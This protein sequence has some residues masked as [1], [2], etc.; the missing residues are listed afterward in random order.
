M[1]TLTAT[2]PGA[3]DYEEVREVVVYD[4]EAAAYY[5]NVAVAY[6]EFSEVAALEGEVHSA[7]AKKPER[8][9]AKHKSDRAYYDGTSIALD[10][11]YESLTLPL[12]SAYPATYRTR[13]LRRVRESVFIPAISFLYPEGVAVTHAELRVGGARDEVLSKVIDPNGVIE[14]EEAGG[15]LRFSVSDLPA[16]WDEDGAPDALSSGPAVLLA[17]R[18]GRLEGTKG[19]FT[20]WA[21]LGAWTAELLADRSELPDGARREI[22]ALVADTSDPLERI[23]RV[24]AYMQA[25]THYVSIQ[26]GIGGF[27]PMPPADVHRYGYGDCKALSNYTRLLLGAAGVDAYYCVIGVGERAISHPGFTSVNQANHAVLAVPFATDTVW[28]ECTSQTTPPGFLGERAAGRY[29]LLVKDGTGSL[30][31]TGGRAPGDN[32]R[33]SSSI[34]TVD[35]LGV[36]KLVRTTRFTGAQVETPLRLSLLDAEERRRVAR[37]GYR[38]NV[39]GLDPEIAIG[40]TPGG[41]QAIMRETARFPNL[42][43]RVGKRFVLPAF[44][45]LY[46]PPAPHD[47]TERR[48]PVEVELGYLHIDTVSYVLPPGTSLVA[49]PETVLLEGPHASYSLSAKPVEG[50]LEVI[51][52]LEVT[53]GTYPP[54]D[55]AA[56]ARFRE[57][58]DRADGSL[59][60]LA[61][62]SKDGT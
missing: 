31:R 17:P 60:A 58:V 61:P 13:T 24:Y 27:K 2:G 20:T 1:H 43:R 28:L 55:A 52:S 54:A 48:L 18:E 25:R 33:E 42:T 57:S 5:R 56:M 4:S 9:R 15:V 3:Y 38:V 26:L 29:A 59:I 53:A 50:G 51:R 45:H 14:R 11:R 8:G 34:L 23:R 12:P 22:E 16:Y 7:G 10:L 21:G 30:V 32:R 40:S 46:P 39:D 37:R 49:V 6:D 19:N 44:G 35:S 41:P 47:T 36:A 62:K